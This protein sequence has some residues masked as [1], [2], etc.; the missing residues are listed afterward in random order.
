MTVTLKPETEARLRERAQ[1]SGVDMDTLADTLLHDVLSDDPDDLTEEE[2]AEIRAGIRR[3]ME[4]FAAGRARSAKD[5]MADI[6]KRR[7]A[8]QI[9]N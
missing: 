6:Q 1:R 2:I 4:A 5:Y 8:R 7:A 9:E 3:G